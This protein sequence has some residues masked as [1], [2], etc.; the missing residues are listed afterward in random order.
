M[1]TDQIASS[2]IASSLIA[3]SPIGGMHARDRA[4]PPAGRCAT[5]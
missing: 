5:S 1:V 2:Q 4:K 3:S